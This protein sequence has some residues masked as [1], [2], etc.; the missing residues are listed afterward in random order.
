M[1]YII[2]NPDVFR[3]NVRCKLNRKIQEIIENSDNKTRNTE[4]ISANLEISIF[5]YSIKEATKKKIVKTWQNISFCQLYIDRLRTVFFNLKPDII[6]LVINGEIKIQ[7]VGFMTHQ[8]FDETKW[9]DLIEKKIKR[10]DSKFNAKIEA[11]T[12]LFNCKK[13]GSNK[14]T[15]Y[16]LQ[17]RSAD[18]PATIFI[19]CLTCGKHWKI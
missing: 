9:K 8:E 11:S 12:S 10:D 3:N 1:S 16:E 19:T 7:E 18:E 5:N 17:I 15:Y 2:K 6:G 4:R 14:C 13:C